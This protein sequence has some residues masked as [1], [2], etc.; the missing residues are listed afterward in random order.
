MKKYFGLTGLFLLVLIFLASC[1]KNTPAPTA[2]ITSTV[3]GNVVVFKDV[4]TN[5][6]KYSWD[7]GDG[8][9]VSTI[10][11]PTHT[12]AE[13]GKTY[14][15]KLTAS[16]AGGDVI[17]TATVIIPPMT[18]M[19][20]LT[21][22]AAFAIGKRWRMSAS[23]EAFGALPDANL[24]LVKQYPVG[25][26]SLIGMGQVYTD[27]YIFFND[28]KFT[29]SPKGGGV[30]A[31]YP[32]CTVNQIANVPTSDGSAV[33]LTYAK[34]Y[35]PPTGVTFAVNEGKSLTI[36][37]TADGI[38]TTNVTY[39]NLTTL[40]FTNKGFIGIMDFMS[41]CVVLDLASDKLKIAFFL[42]AVPPNAPQV[43]KI[44]NVLIFSFEVVQ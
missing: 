1:K 13:Y 29:I 18:K 33:G 36:A 35:T 21:G 5:A 38:T 14:N 37:T 12:Y 9:A 19:E 28:G 24:T 20:M 42:S 31:G 22:G 25:V 16:G 32:Y 23:A 26:L 4:T 43:G 11:N 34:P 39:N 41:E 17:A 27:E 40:S 10:Q 2:T 3:T 15:V 44:T 30:F 6:D 8:G 7:F